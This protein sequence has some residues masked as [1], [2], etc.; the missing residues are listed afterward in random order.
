[1]KKVFVLVS[2]AVLALGLVGCGD[3]KETSQKESSQS[4]QSQSG[5]NIA[6]QSVK[7]DEPKS[8]SFES[9]PLCEKVGRSILLGSLT[10]ESRRLLSFTS[11]I[12]TYEI[13]PQQIQDLTLSHLGAN[14]YF[15]GIKRNSRES[16][17]VYTL[18][19]DYLKTEISEEELLRF[20]QFLAQNQLYY[21]YEQSEE[22][23]SMFLHIYKL[24]KYNNK[25]EEMYRRGSDYFENFLAIRDY[26]NKNAI[27]GIYRTRM[28]LGVLQ[29][30]SSQYI[31]VTEME[32]ELANIIDSCSGEGYKAI[33]ENEESEKCKVRKEYCKNEADRNIKEFKAI[34][35]WVKSVNEGKEQRSE[36]VLSST[37][38]TPKPTTTEN[39]TNSTENSLSVDSN[40]NAEN[41]ANS[42][43]NLPV[44]K[45]AT[46]DDY[47][48]L[49]KAP[50]GEIITPIYKKDFEAISLKKVGESGKW[51]KVLYFP[52]NKTDEKDAITG[53][54]HIS[55]IAK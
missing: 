50:S 18:T 46:K 26:L 51:I 4:E 34:I 55:Q 54:I 42:S 24:L 28:V 36:L 48:N 21:Q 32:N 14:G 6:T 19:F 9:E 53:Y 2:I 30:E 12:D 7:Q 31:R 8:Q 15:M 38:N 33:C 49:R 43:T 25:I 11:G 10:W 17:C 29:K 5:D 1:M 44:I 37:Q 39:A 35:A 47:V 22:S 40:A 27:Q 20:E 41:L 45:L 23:K 16:L 13:T 52:P 3:S